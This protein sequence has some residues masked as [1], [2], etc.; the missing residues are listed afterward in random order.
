MP[1][2]HPENAGHWSGN[3]AYF[4]AEL[5]KLYI[6][7]A[8]QEQ[9]RA[10]KNNKDAMEEEKEA[11]FDDEEAEHLDE[12][13]IGLIDEKE[14][15]DEKKEEENESDDEE[16]EDDAVSEAAGAEKEAKADYL[17]DE[18]CHA[19]IMEMITYVLKNLV[20]SRDGKVIDQVAK[21]CRVRGYLN[22]F[23]ANFLILETCLL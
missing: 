15:E 1:F 20:Y 14:E 22:E 12:V 17:L 9:R 13:D 19:K 11:A 6:K 8:N 21:T 5:C 23:Q 7:R 3:L 16:P 4:Y 18:G 10:R 2:I